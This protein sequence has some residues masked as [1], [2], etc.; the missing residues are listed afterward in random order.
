[1]GRPARLTSRPG[2]AISRV[3][4]VRATV[5]SPSTRASLMMAVHRIRLWASTAHCSH[6]ELAWKLPEGT[7]SSPAPSL[8]SRMASSTA[9]WRRWNWSA[10]TVAQVEVGDEGVVAPVG[11]QPLL[12]GAGEPGAAHDET[13]PTLG[14]LAVV[15]AGDVGG[16]GDLSVTAVGVGDVDP[17]VLVDGGDR[18]ADAGLQAH[19]DRP[20]D[21]EPV[22]GVDQLP[23]VEAGVGAHRQRP[24]GTGSAQAGD[25]FGVNRCTPRWV[26]AEPLRIRACSTSPVS[27]RVASSG[28]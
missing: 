3:R 1:M 5:S 16:L 15:S 19:R 14:S 12:G 8:R 9:A 4:M 10:S 22:E 11:P 13:H 18:R 24:T 25:H 7:W 21:I 2:S 20:G 28:W 26:L 23:A 17:V 27:A 6:A